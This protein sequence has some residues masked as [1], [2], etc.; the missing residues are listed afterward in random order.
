MT[1]GTVQVRHLACRSGLAA[2]WWSL[3]SHFQSVWALLGSSPSV[4]DTH[5]WAQRKAKER[6]EEEN[7]KEH[8]VRTVCGRTGK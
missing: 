7:D 6:E 3:L 8:T 1:S 4:L 2:Q 5:S